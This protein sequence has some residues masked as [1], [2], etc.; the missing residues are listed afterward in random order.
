MANENDKER[1]LALADGDNTQSKEDTK[2][3]QELEFK[4][5][6]KKVQ[7]F[8]KKKSYTRRVPSIQNLEKDVLQCIIGQ[9]KQVRQ[10][11]TAIYRSIKL[12][13]IK[14]NVLIIGN[15][16]TGKTETI[17]QVAKRLNIPYT[18]EDATK[19]T[20]EGYYGNNVEDMV[21][22]LIDNANGDLERAEKGI[23]VID[24]IDK[25]AGRGIERDVAGAEVLKSLLKIIEGTTIA[26]ISPE[27]II[28]EE[29][30]S[31]DT[32]NLIIIFL[33]A[34]EGL[35]EIRQK[36]LNR[37]PLGFVK[38]ADVRKTDERYL[39]KDLVEYGM[40]EEFVGRID[41]IIEMNKL[42]KENLTLILKK[43]KL[44]VFLKYENELKRKGLTLVYDEEKLFENIAEAS[45]E[46]DTGARELANTVNY[47]FENIIYDILVNPK[48]YTK[49]ILESGIVY[50]NTK[51][52]L[53]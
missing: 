40:P 22:N 21:Y 10:I 32:K 27:N 7:D 38:N 48:K 30:T 16:G 19:Y 3:E 11:I 8:E 15:S 53:S 33:G 18:I 35:D 49:C 24:E 23:I 39:K 20:Q 13:N 25:K 41:T 42:D 34:F 46:L 2:N 45:L 9:D 28:D 29:F 14:S 47:I 12:K 31:F 37:N 50:D 52:Q 43:S 51:Y 1:N 44:S 4:I 6:L 17:K 26:Y 5:D 36:R